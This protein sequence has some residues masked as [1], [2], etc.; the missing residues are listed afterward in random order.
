MKTF[1][2]IAIRNALLEK[3]VTL[4]APATDDTFENLKTWLGKPI[5]P[6]VISLMRQFDGFSDGD[7]EERSFV[8]VWAMEKAIRDNWSKRPLLAFSDWSLNAIIFGFDP[9]T[10]G[11]VISIEDGL[12]VAPSYADFWSLLLADRIF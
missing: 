2:P 12:V 11:P 10:V 8:S 7:F 6:D 4:N 3:N 1:D 9:S 5:H